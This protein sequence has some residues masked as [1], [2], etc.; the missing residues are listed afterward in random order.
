MIYIEWIERI[1]IGAAGI[2]SLITLYYMIRMY[3]SS[4]PKI[5]CELAWDVLNSNHELICEVTVTNIGSHALYI[6]KVVL[7]VHDDEISRQERIGCPLPVSSHPKKFSFSQQ[8]L[9]RFSNDWRIIRAV[10]TDSSGDKH[11]SKIPNEGNPPSF[12]TSPASSP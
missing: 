4:K 3:L 1:T 5:K 7:S 10:A 12:V 9:N 8:G 2:A 6:N 11:R